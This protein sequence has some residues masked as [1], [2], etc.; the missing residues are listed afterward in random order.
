MRL[1]VVS[2]VALLGAFG[3]LGC[4]TVADRALMFQ[5][6]Q[7]RYTQ[8]M[9]YTDFGR[10]GHFVAPDARSEFREATSALGDL[11]FTDYEIRDIQDLGSTAT[12]EVQYVGYRASDPVVVTYVEKQEWERDG[13][14]WVV[15]PHMSVQR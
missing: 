14:V 6:T 9:R 15:R 10:A 8:L 13:G 5:E 12:A 1:R 11:H 7:R 2:I 4:A 3:G